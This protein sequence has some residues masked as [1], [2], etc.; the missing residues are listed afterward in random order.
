M[1]HNW[2][3]I[4]AAFKE[5]SEEEQGDLIEHFNQVSYELGDKLFGE[6]EEDF[7]NAVNGLNDLEL[8]NLVIAVRESELLDVE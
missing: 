3:E 8:D 2:G 6:D 1:I 4:E 5:A 7:V